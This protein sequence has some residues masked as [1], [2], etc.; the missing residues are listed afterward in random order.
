MRCEKSGSRGHD[1]CGTG[2]ETG[3]CHASPMRS[4]KLA[5]LRRAICRLEFV[6]LTDG[7]I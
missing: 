7:R 5:S 4:A 1:R 2:A 6:E 3:S